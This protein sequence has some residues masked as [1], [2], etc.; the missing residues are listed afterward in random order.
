MDSKFNKLF[1]T[2]MEDVKSSKI[3]AKRVIKED[4]IDDQDP[5]DY[6]Q[7]YDDQDQVEYDDYEI[8]DIN[9]D[10][11]IAALDYW[12]E[13]GAPG[14]T[15]WGANNGPDLND[16]DF[17]DEFL[18]AME[19]NEEVVEG[20]R[21]GIMN[22]QQ[23][24][25][26]VGKWAANFYN[27]YQL[28]ESEQESMF[29]DMY[30]Q[31]RGLFDDLFVEIAKRDLE[32]FKLALI[33]IIVD[34]PESSSCAI[35]QDAVTNPEWWR[36]NGL[37]ITDAQIQ[38]INDFNDFQSKTYEH[39][40]ASDDY[41]DWNYPED[42]MMHLGLEEWWS[43]IIACGRIELGNRHPQGGWGRDLAHYT[44][45]VEELEAKHPEFK[46][47]RPMVI[48]LYDNKYKKK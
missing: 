17:L 1:N 12:N 10:K 26:P 43:Y 41:C 47:Y 45:K 23:L 39:C 36:Q 33:P 3:K 29:D 22:I 31:K 14:L 27:N 20:L 6:N 15:D 25:G 2:I 38:E 8:I 40:F 34:N 42:L 44:K 46:K 48:E 18:D 9:Q 11:L 21:K 32:K 37:N 13:H 35:D 19:E 16:S 28:S 5:E 7:D 30:Y 24:A 4:V